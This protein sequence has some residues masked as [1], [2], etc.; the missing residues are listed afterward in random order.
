M[1]AMSRTTSVKLY[2]VWWT[3]MAM[4]RPFELIFACLLHS[5]FLLVAPKFSPAH[6]RLHVAFVCLY[7]QLDLILYS[8]P[9]IM[10][11]PCNA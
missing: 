11:K 7:G 5:S 3:C 10:R 8:T 4:E 2:N 6:G 9:Y 1:I